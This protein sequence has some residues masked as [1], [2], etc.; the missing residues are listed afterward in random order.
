MPAGAH[1][2]S[3]TTQDSIVRWFSGFL[4][5]DQASSGSRVARSPAHGVDDRSQFQQAIEFVVREPVGR[6]ISGGGRVA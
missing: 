4:L 5:D 3:R 1:C 2:R 6:S